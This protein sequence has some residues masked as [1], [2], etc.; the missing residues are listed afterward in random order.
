MGKILVLWGLVFVGV[1]GVSKGYE[2][3]EYLN[4]TEEVF[5]QDSGFGVSAKNNPLTVGLTVIHGAAAQRAGTLSSSVCVCVCDAFF[6]LLKCY[7]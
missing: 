4:G 6:L 3:D 5:A 1:L 2:Y 7:L